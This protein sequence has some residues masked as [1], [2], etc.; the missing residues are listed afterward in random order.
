MMDGGKAKN[1]TLDALFR[2]NVARDPDGVSLQDPPDSGAVTGNPPRSLT[3]AQADRRIGALA[4]LLHEI[5]IPEG[6]T[7]AIQLPNNADSVIA[8][9]AVVR[10][11]MVPAMLPLLWRRAECVAALSRAHATAILCCGRVG[12]FDHG[13]LA[14]EIAAELFPIRAVA[15]F[16]RG[17]ADGIVPIDEVA[18][19]MPPSDEI[20]SFADIAAVTFDVG[21]D[22]PVPVE[23]NAI[24]ILSAGLLIG[25]DAG[26]GR[27]AAILSTVPVSSYAGLSA[28][29]VPWLMSG[30]R[31]EF[32]HP[33]AP[34][35]LSRQIEEADILVLPDAV[36]LR[37]AE[38]SLLGA[39]NL[40]AV[41]SICRSPERFA[42][43]AAWPLTE[44][45]LVDVAAF[46]ELAVLSALRP[47][48]GNP[49]P[50]PLRVR[51]A[52]AESEI[53]QTYVTSAGTLGI[54]G[55]LAAGP[56]IDTG[57]ACTMA[58]EQNAI[59]V[60]AAPSGL[61]NVGGYRFALRDLQHAIRMIDESSLIAALPQSLTGHRLAGHAC[62]PAAMRQTLRDFGLGPLVTG[63]FRDRATQS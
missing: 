41:I 27:G 29:L 47:A 3:Y 4:R 18:G 58:P 40:R 24:Q 61:A 36:T 45:A 34:D 22:G 62:D 51:S 50:W 42:A 31:L 17:L 20:E 55:A 53:A 57:Y 23:R 12:D 28:S 32:H 25:R 33:F 60:T 46:G 14:L 56:D 15:G 2:T 49:A 63:A 21:A 7:V 8:F 37:L 1:A 38:T 19:D 6:G 39:G 30:G 16:G 26:A 48:D 5:G 59:T 9:L 10:A 54:R 44:L 43:A 13:Q 11:G 35:I 52:D